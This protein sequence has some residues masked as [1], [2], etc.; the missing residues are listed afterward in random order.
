MVLRSAYL[1]IAQRL[2]EAADVAHSDV[3]S[4]LNDAV[5]Q[6][7]KGTGT[8]ASYVDHTGDGATGD[9]IY[10]C[11]GD[12][13]S[14]M[15]KAPYEISKVGDKTTASLDTKNAVSVIPQMTYAEQ[16]DEDDHYAQMMERL[17]KDKIYTAGELPLFERFISKSERDGA[18]EASFAGKGKSFPIL[19]PSDVGAAVHAMGRAGSANYGMAQLKANIIR[20]AKAKGFGSELPKAWQGTQSSESA[21]VNVPRGTT[22]ELKLFESASA[23]ETI[24]LTE[25]KADYEI[26]LIAPGKGSSAFYPAEVLKRDGPKVFKAGTH[27]YLN[28]QTAA[29]EAQRPEGDVRNLAGVLSSTAVYHENH[30]KGPGLYGRMKVFQDHA[31]LVEEKAAH[32]GMSIRASG[33]AESGKSHEGLPV[34]KE[35]TGAESVDVVTRA[36]AGGMIL[37]ESA[38]TQE[39]SGMDATELKALQESVKAANDANAKL[40]ERA[41]K[42]DAREEAARILAGI[43]LHEAAKS[44][45][46][47]NVLRDIPQKDGVLD[48]VKW[49]EAVN[50]EAKR[51]G[52]VVSAATG[53]GQVNGMGAGAPI[54]PVTETRKPEEILAHAVKTFQRMGLS[55][56]AAK[57][58]ALGRVA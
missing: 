18:D 55:E 38:R 27:V 58:A 40:L 7:H 13:T 49:T 37:T 25:A 17:V 50:A 51:V 9:C 33:L 5:S 23:L 48:T 10:S 1:L 28:H 24:N 43:S 3:R 29:E 6:A 39:V 53:S 42:G 56:A 36:G 47:E 35:L 4:Q 20:I 46:I 32:V 16:A 34:L 14:G 44:L 57:R 45:V 52:A 31:Q 2:Q 11:Y 30:A 26:K 19:K 22:G 8:Y 15:K 54:V 12:G 41:L 21:V